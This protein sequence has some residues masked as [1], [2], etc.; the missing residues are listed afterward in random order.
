MKVTVKELFLKKSAE[1]DILWPRTL[2]YLLLSLYVHQC[3]EQDNMDARTD[4]LTFTNSIF[5]TAICY[6]L[7]INELA[8]SP[9]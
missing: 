1:L 9:P 7:S 4:V 6:V 8:K 3:A 5:T 2:I